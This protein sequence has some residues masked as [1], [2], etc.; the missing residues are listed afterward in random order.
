MKTRRK[1]GLGLAIIV[2][3]AFGGT[4]AAFADNPVKSSNPS[5]S[6]QIFVGG[7][8]HTM[9]AM[10]DRLFVTGH[11]GAG[12]SDD[13]G[14]TWIPLTSLKEAD[15]MSW[16]S[17]AST[18]L[19]GGHV[20]LFKSTDKGLTF[21]KVKFFGSAT[22]VHAIGASG[23]VVYLGSPQVGLL[24][25][26]NGGNT[27]KVRNAKIG[28]GFMGSMLIDPKNSK[29]IIAPDMAQGLVTSTDGGLTWSGFGGPPGPMAVAWNAKNQN[30]IA[31]IGMM[32]SG[33]SSNGGKTWTEMSVPNGAAAIDYSSDGKNLLIAALVG[34]KA[35]IYS[36][37][38]QGK[39]WQ[40]SATS[41]AL[42]KQIAMDPNM[43]GM[44]H[45]TPTPTNR[46]VAL[47][48]GTFGVGTSAVFVSAI[49]LRKKDRAKMATRKTVA[50]SRGDGK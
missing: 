42:K 35:Q 41:P 49:F 13:G 30:D 4:S 10:R 39:S 31:A 8:L 6:H 45:S 48:L 37:A 38:N 18:I 21:K 50:A 28:Q 34:T 12:M 9:T 16:T 19:A 3:I 7:H 1:K 11:D 29:R 24:I 2:A 33:F 17:V 5:T 27:W 15:I 32:T 26:N 20:G 25:S 47:T 40:E 36:S 23:K 44:A 43:P 14:K 22:D 46:P